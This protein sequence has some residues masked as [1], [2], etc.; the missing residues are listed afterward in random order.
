MRINFNPI[1]RFPILAALCLLT[2]QFALAQNPT[3]PSGQQIAA[4]VD[5]YMNAAVK[6]DG[7]SGSILVARDGQPI[8]SKSYGMANIELNVPNTPQ[9]VFRVASV[10]KQFTATAIMMLQERGKLNV[11]DPI[12]KYLADCPA[13]WQP[14]TVHQLLVHTSG[15]PSYTGLPD[16]WEKTSALPMTATEL[17]ARIK[18]MPL[19]FVPGEKFNYNN[20]GWYLLG[21]I[22]ERTSG[23][24]YGDFLQE[25]IFTPLGM[26]QTGFD[27]SRRIIKNRAAGYMRQG[28]EL[29][30]AKYVDMTVPFAAGGLLTTTEDLF[31]WDKALYTE[32]LI[33][34]KSRDEMF[35][36]FKESVPGASFGYGWFTN[37]WFDHQMIGHNGV[38][39]GFRA[40][41]ARFPEK[42]VTVIVL[43]NNESAFSGKT[44]K[45]L[46][47]IVFGAAYKIPQEVKTVAV[48]QK[49]LQQ[50]VGEYE[51]GRTVTLENGKLMFQR[52]GRPK[53]ELFAESETRFPDVAW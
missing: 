44:A 46:A 39:E 27:D 20:S 43:T 52:S 12:C 51:G 13:T 50:Y 1:N 25:N 40:M 15:I 28:N 24:S 4:K 23:K 9:T 35:T 37:K 53:F 38:L 21:L 8:V 32:K 14:I 29:V 47:A 18:P 16:F 34:A 11:N 26:K 3:A 5:E 10:T 45:D 41:I 6:I 19:E 31:L 48:D 22:V 30:N 33:S 7:F 42:R 17:L 2:V 49:I 36:P